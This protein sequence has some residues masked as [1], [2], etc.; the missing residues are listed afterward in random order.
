MQTSRTNW[1]L[2]PN[3]LLALVPVGA[4]FVAAGWPP[5][6]AAA[7]PPVAGHGLRTVSHREQW[8]YRWTGNYGSPHFCVSNP[9]KQGHD[10]V[11]IFDARL[12][13]DGRTVFLEIDE[14]APVMQMQIDLALAGADGQEVRRTLMATINMVGGE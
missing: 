6:D 2:L 1:K 9:N 11:E 8:N 5:A 14:L 4:F 7:N 3:Y 13:D 12:S 10:E